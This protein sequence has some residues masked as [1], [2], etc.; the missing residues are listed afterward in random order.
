[1][2]KQY[3][4]E[5]FI[6][7]W[8]W[9]KKECDKLVSFFKKN[10][11]FQQPGRTSNGVDPDV[12]Q[13]TDLWLLPSNKIFINYNKYLNTCIK[14][15][16]NTYELDLSRFGTTPIYE[17]R[18]NIQ[19]YKPGEG[20]KKWHCERGNLRNTHRQFVFMTYLNDVKDGGTEFK[21][22]KIITEA[23]KGL[24]LLWPSDFTHTHRGQITSN[25]E[26][27]IVTGWLSYV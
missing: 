3:P 23:K 27:Y 4:K 10:K 19:Y 6:Q 12:K 1:M 9:D 8:Y 25:S 21:F 18:Y 7:G 24:T 26:K 20:Y 2:K 11:K 16:E 15:Y 22:Q 5:S 13:S 17:D 14:D